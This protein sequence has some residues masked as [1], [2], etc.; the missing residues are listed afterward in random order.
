VITWPFLGLMALVAV[1][2]GAFFVSERR[3]TE[4]A[5]RDQGPPTARFNASYA[6]GVISTSLE[7]AHRRALQALAEIG[8][9]TIGEPTMHLIRAQQG[10]SIASY[11]SIVSIWLNPSG[12]GTWFQIDSRP[13]FRW[14][15]ADL[16][17]PKNVREVVKV[18]AA[19]GQILPPPAGTA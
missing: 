4:R 11:G 19:D 17:G 14:T 9:S 5:A 8:A 16:R 10:W 15:L 1:L 18:L 13:K 2:N 3:A 7:V 6:Q 12:D